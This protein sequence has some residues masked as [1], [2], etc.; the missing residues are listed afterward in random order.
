[1][2][3]S[4]K[5]GAI[6]KE[7]GEYENICNASKE[8]KYKCPEC[9]GDV[10]LRKGEKNRV[11]FAHKKEGNCEHYEHPTESEIHKEGKRVI[12]MLVEKNQL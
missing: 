8:K 9:E 6:K 2:E 11:H 10:I 1:M 5:L 7:N 12:K 4:I 3:R